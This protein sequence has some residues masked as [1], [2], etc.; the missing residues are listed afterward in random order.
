MTLL[1]VAIAV[2]WTVGCCWRATRAQAA[3]APVEG[4]GPRTVVFDVPN[5]ATRA[6]AVDAALRS[7][8]DRSDLRG[9]ADEDVAIVLRGADDT[10]AGHGIERLVATLAR[11][12]VG[13][14][15]AAVRASHT[16]TTLARLQ[17]MEWVGLTE[18]HARRG[19]ALGALGA[20]PASPVYR[21]SALRDV[22]GWPSSAADDVVVA[23][24]L[25]ARGWATVL[26]PSAIVLRPPAEGFIELV[27]ARAGSMVGILRAL[28]FVPSLVR[29]RRGGQAAALLAPIGLLLAGIVLAVAAVAA[30][31]DPAGAARVLVGADGLRLVAWYAVLFAP[32]W[33]AGFTYWSRN[34][35]MSLRGSIALGHLFVP[36]SLHWVVAAWL[37]ALRAPF[38]RRAHEPVTVAGDAAR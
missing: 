26:S 23:A 38:R 15:Q 35:A 12:E 1:A 33:V 30:A 28:R 24:A 29:A 37:G 13:A 6:V 18:L 7:L 16:D 22:E 10:I 31:L 3:V 5:D 2:V 21:W 17:D 9:V 32:A 14:V 11:P 34:D 4:P 36:Y 20:G 25:A 27:G 8:D 19:Q